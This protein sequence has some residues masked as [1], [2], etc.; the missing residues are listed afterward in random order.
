MHTVIGI[1][2]TCVVYFV[3]NYHCECRKV[4]WLMI[5]SDGTIFGCVLQKI[6]R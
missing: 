6:P 3:E 4:K 5:F 1:V 2:V